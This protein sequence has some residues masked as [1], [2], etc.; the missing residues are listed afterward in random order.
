[1]T[2]TG[3]L[4]GIWLKRMKRGPMDITD[5]AN[6]EAGKGLVGNA[7]QGG[8]RQVTL[9]EQEIWQQIVSDIDPDLNPSTRRANL[10]LS[11]IRLKKT[12]NQILQIGQCRIRIW[13]ETRP[14]NVMDEVHPG[15]QAALSP[16]W[17]GGA[18]GEVLDDGEISV[19]DVVQWVT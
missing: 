8:K 11:G 6:L 10:L 12:H 17:G 9:L 7:N 3:R 15:L 13:G 4:E 1:M 5:T 14:C 19:G 18:Y 2:Q 16:N